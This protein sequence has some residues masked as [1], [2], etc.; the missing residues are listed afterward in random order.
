MLMVEKQRAHSLHTADAG[1]SFT[2]NPRD[3]PVRPAPEPICTSSPCIIIES[4]KES[5]YMYTRKRKEKNLL[6]IYL[7]SPRRYAWLI[8][9][10]Q[11]SAAFSLCGREKLGELQP[12]VIAIYPEVFHT[13]TGA[14]YEPERFTGGPPAVGFCCIMFPFSS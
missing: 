2:F 4:I 6:D 8:V 1:H 10:S 7:P 5:K 11:I 12:A 3:I 13:S 9:S 14:A